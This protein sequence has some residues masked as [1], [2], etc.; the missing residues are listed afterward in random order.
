MEQYRLNGMQPWCYF[1]HRMTETHDRRMLRAVWR[2]RRICVPK[3]IMG[4][5]NGR[6]T[7]SQIV[8]VG[9]LSRYLQCRSHVVAYRVRTLFVH[10]FVLIILGNFDYFAF[11]PI[12]RWSINNYMCSRSASCPTTRS[13]WALSTTRHI[14]V[15]SWSHVWTL[16]NGFLVGF[17]IIPRILSSYIV[18]TDVRSEISWLSARQLQTYRL[19]N[20]SERTPQNFWIKLT[21]QK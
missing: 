2:L 19:R 15:R 17:G 6:E 9:L 21:P 1:V 4:Q 12:A 18:S 7:Q 14:A 3:N 11:W 10:V 8:Q 16:W 5:T 20:R 13:A